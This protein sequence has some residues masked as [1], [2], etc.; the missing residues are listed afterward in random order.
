MLVS[1]R[2][3]PLILLIAFTPFQPLS[4]EMSSREKELNRLMA[5]LTEDTLLDYFHPKIVGSQLVLE[6]FAADS[7]VKDS[8]LLKLRTLD[9]VVSIDDQV[10]ILTLSDRERR[11]AEDLSGRLLRAF[12]RSISLERADI[13]IRVEKSKITLV[14][15]VDTMLQKEVAEAQA[16]A[17]PRVRSVVN[18][19]SVRPG[20]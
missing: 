13:R 2:L 8:L 19:L 15:F 11:T 12:G 4:Q 10:E 18:Q 20:R 9:W 3:L 16:L 7:R 6:G 14:G 1:T 5:E 17:T